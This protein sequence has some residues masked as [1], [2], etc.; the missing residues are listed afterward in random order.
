MNEQPDHLTPDEK[1]RLKEIRAAMLELRK[2]RDAIQTRAR[3]R[4][5]R[6]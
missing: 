5:H 4:K 3:V 2:E 1:R 6:A